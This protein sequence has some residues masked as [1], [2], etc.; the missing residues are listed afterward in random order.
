MQ[1]IRYS[2]DR[3]QEWDDFVKASKN[4]SFLFVRGYMDYH[5]D[6]FKD[7][8]LM[9]YNA[10]GKLVGVMAANQRERSLYSHQ[11]LT[12]GGLVLSP[13][14]RMSDVEE[15][16]SA[17]RRY[18]QDVGFDTWYYKQTPCVYHQLPAE[19]DEYWLW[20][21]GAVVTDCNMM[22]AIPLDAP[23]VPLEA[24]RRN[25]Y[26]RL[27][28][29]GFTVDPDA[30]LSDFW[31]ILTGNLELRFG[32]KPVH[33]LEEMS[34]LKSRFPQRIR[35]CVV[36]NA[37]GEI[38]AGVILYISDT[39][40]KTQYSSASIAGKRCKALDFLLLHLVNHYR[41][42]G[43]YKWFEFGTSMAEDGVCLNDSLLAQKEGFG[44]RSIACRI[45]RMDIQAGR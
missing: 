21:C 17:T 43:K 33:T 7:H 36:R 10:K 44:A 41:D 11:G 1:I 25:N 37:E 15:M 22:S 28:R 2:P 24:S 39:V 20:R 31:P 13:K 4:G 12:F 40:V 9:Y 35:C 34:L 42:L 30:P 8:S 45:Y 14:T 27:S 38:Q 32:A 23:N 5:S 26:N 6:R 19:E 16:F 29:L 18:L 3:Q